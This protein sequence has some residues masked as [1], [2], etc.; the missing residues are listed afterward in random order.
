MHDDMHLADYDSICKSFFSVSDR[1]ITMSLPGQM[2]EHH[3]TYIFF[4]K[5]FPYSWSTRTLPE[6]LSNYFGSR[7][8]GPTGDPYPPRKNHHED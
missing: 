8:I 6:I 7:I 3:D 2:A 4:T 5:V 1:E